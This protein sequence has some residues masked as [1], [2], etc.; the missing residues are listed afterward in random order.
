MQDNDLISDLLC[1][2]DPVLFAEKRLGYKPDPWQK[3][4]LTPS[5]PR[6]L[7]LCSRQVG[8][9]TTAAARAVHTAVYEPDSLTL[10]IAPTQRQSREAFTKVGNFVKDLQ[11]VET[12]DED[13]KLS[14]TLR[15]GS[16]I[17][18]LPGDNPHSI[19]GFSA[20]RLII[21]D[22]S[23]WVKDT[24]H[25]ALRPMLAASPN[26]QLVLMSTPFGRRGHFFDAWQLGGDLWHRISITAPECPRI[27]PGWLEAERA[28]I[29]D[30]RF[31]Q[32][33]LCE[34]V[35]T[36]DQL[37]S[38]DLVQAAFSDEIEPL[39]TGAELAAIAGA[40]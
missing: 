11:P 26:G 30:W 10:I 14:L 27:D 6:V 9:T 15:N 17:V 32:E 29:G 35:E 39:F 33:Y 38:F 31:R 5:S 16:R 12:L 36:T 7:A 34:F 40:R 8:K 37:F 24:T 1:A 18:A 22:E 4:F 28:Q 25:T 3:D 2:A 23:A 21:E 20:P 13:N 19:R